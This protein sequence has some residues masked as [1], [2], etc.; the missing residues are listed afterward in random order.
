MALAHAIPRV[1]ERLGRPRQRQLVIRRHRIRRRRRLA[2]LRRQV[3]AV[4]DGEVAAVARK[5]ADGVV[6]VADEDNVGRQVAV[7]VA[8][9]LL[10]A[11]GQHDAK[12]RVGRLVDDRRHGLGDALG[13]LAALVQQVRKR[14]GVRLVVAVAGRVALP[15]AQ[16]PD[17]AA[18]PNVREEGADAVAGDEQAHVLL[19][20]LRA[21]AVGKLGHAAQLHGAR[22]LELVAGAKVLPNLAVTAVRG[23]QEVALGRLGAVWADERHAQAPVGQLLDFAGAGAPRDG[24]LR[25]GGLDERRLERRPADADRG[26]GQAIDGLVAHRE[27][28]LEVLVPDVKGQARVDTLDGLRGDLFE[29]AKVSAHEEGAVLVCAREAHRVRLAVDAE[30][31]RVLVDDAHLG[32]GD[33]RVPVLVKG[34]RKGQPAHARAGDED[35][36]AREEMTCFG[37]GG[38]VFCV[39]GFLMLCCGVC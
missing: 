2:Q 1:L 13:H 17:H 28:R 38:H 24:V 31:A 34:E 9:R 22:V 8:K 18:R 27:E 29:Q 37:V 16:A 14:L 19:E 25:L 30:V 35:L 26:R 5:R 21:L 11:R 3:P 12:R 6:G 23:D 15:L 33:A 4:L 36:F 10:V 7:L 39:V 32:R 20:R